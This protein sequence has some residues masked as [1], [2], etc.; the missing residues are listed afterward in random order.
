[1]KFA[2]EFREALETEGFPAR[3]VQHAVP[4]GEL[5]KCLKKVQSE[6]EG[7]GLDSATIAQ[8]RALSDQE[9]STG[10]RGSAFQYNFDG[11]QKPIPKLTLF[12]QFED[13]IAVDA[14]LTPDT[15][16][17]LE[18][19]AEKGTP[20]HSLV[21]TPEP[22]EASAE[23]NGLHLPEEAISLHMK[24]RI[25]RV[26]IP[27]TFDAKFFD[28]LLDDVN[29]L[30]A[31]QAEEQKALGNEILALSKEVTAVTKPSKFKKTDMYR[32]RELIDIYL[33]AGIFFSTHEIDHGKR[34]GAAA[35]R[36]LQWFQSEVRRRELPESFKLPA[37]LQAFKRFVDINIILLLNLK[38]Q[39]MNRRAFDK[40]LKKFDKRTQLGVAGTLPKLIQ[41]D[42]IMS[43][44]MSKA[45]CA[46][47]STDLVKIVPQVDDY[48]CPICSEV[49]WRPVRMKCQHLFCSGCAVK[50]QKQR[51]KFCPLCREDVVLEA[52]EDSIDKELE[53]FLEK[54]FP[55]ECKVKKIEYETA[56]GIEQ[57][58]PSYKH[59]S[60][61]GGCQTM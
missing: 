45:I 39:E 48:S 12:V 7:L 56:A 41:S 37:S 55:K 25:R 49:Q 23:K 59:P 3:W 51:R 35:S 53:K 6:L 38:F 27:L 36:Q 30:D 5:K 52:D 44:T 42:S 43:E 18:A 22:S 11:S 1:M 13:G 31:L 2:H 17:Y 61:G 33:Q 29:S 34:D 50:M 10:R 8:L 47:M 46:Q 28:L 24:P 26:E 4:Y 15:K 40:I 19:L 16:R 58:G 54:R 32:W 21:G 60:E 20:I 9:P 14:A 57:F